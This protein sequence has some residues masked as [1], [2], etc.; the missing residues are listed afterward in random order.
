MKPLLKFLY[1]CFLAFSSGVYAN[2]AVVNTISKCL[3]YEDLKTAETQYSDIEII[4]DYTTNNYYKPL[5]RHLRQLET[6]SSCDNYAQLLNK[7]LKKMP[8]I[9]GQKVY[10]G[11]SYRKSFDDLKIGDCFSDKGFVSTSFD[12][13]VAEDFYWS[14]Y[15][16]DENGAVIFDIISVTGRDISEMSAAPE[17]R[18]VLLLPNT[19]LKL[20]NTGISKEY[21]RT[22]YFKEIESK[23][24][25]IIKF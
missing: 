17:E 6:D 8:E 13:K 7:A 14:T 25:S 16:F 24:C 1:L 21:L 5:N 3:K 18:E 9:Q 4:Q 15:S 12:L 22:Y 11:T 20:V 19:V 23:E 2:S 10:R